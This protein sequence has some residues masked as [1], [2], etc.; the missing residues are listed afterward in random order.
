MATKLT[1]KYIESLRV[2]DRKYT[3]WDSIL[4]GFGCIVHLTGRKVYIYKYRN[5]EKKQVV[6]TFGKHGLLTTEMARNMSQQLV[7]K[8]SN[9]IDPKEEKAQQKKDEK[10]SILFKD[11][12]DIFEEKY[13]QLNHK[14]KTILKDQYRVKKYIIPFLGKKVLSTIE[15]KDILDFCDYMSHV[16]GALSRSLGLLS[17]AFNQAEL[18]EYRRSGSN[19]TVGVKKQASKKMERFLT[20]QERERIESFLSQ[21]QTNSP[22]TKSKIKALQLLLYTGCRESEITQLKWDEVNL[23]D[24]YL[25]LKDESSKSNGRSIKAGT[26]T[27]PLNPRALKILHGVD[28]ND[29]NPYVFGGEKF[30]C[31]IYGVGNFWISLRGKLGLEDVRLHDLRHSFASF[32]LKQGVDLYT[33]SKLL[34]HKNIA[35]TTRYAHLE[36]DHLKE[37]TNKIF[38]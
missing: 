3:V 33:V 7:L 27:V 14:P 28:R 11:F 17:C 22:V 36:L 25:Y 35:T 18:W 37:A 10:S 24:K 30:G 23:E 15:R 32:A 4:T 29:L 19:P 9:G 34:G 12:W 5:L 26:R 2:R 31:A 6:V 21:Y 8:I 38:G 1:K 13:I 16:P 20:T